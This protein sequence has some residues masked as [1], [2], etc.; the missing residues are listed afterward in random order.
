MNDRCYYVNIIEKK[1]NYILIDYKFDSFNNS[2]ILYVNLF[3]GTKVDTNI[4]INTKINILYA[5]F[6][7]FKIGQI[8]EV[9]HIKLLI[10]NYDLRYNGYTFDIITKYDFQSISPYYIGYYSLGLINNYN[11]K[12]KQLT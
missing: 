12:N 1:E 8:I 5:S 4:F 11:T 7:E 9:S 2:A 6:G 10:K 3:E